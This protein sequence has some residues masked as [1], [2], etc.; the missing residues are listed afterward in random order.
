MTPGGMV[1]CRLTVHDISFLQVK[2]VWAYVSFRGQ[3]GPNMGIFLPKSCF[4][5]K[6]KMGPK[7]MVRMIEK[8]TNMKPHLVWNI[9]IHHN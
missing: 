2:K 3:G 4:L 9:E 6:V 5:A 1:L 7:K 8:H